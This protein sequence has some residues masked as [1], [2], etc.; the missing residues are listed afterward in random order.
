[1]KIAFDFDLLFS[2]F[3]PLYINFN[4]YT[5]PLF[6]RNNITMAIEIK[7]IS[8]YSST[9][10]STM[11]AVSLFPC[12]GWKR[13]KRKGRRNYIVEQTYEK[14]VEMGRTSRRRDSRRKHGVSMA[15]GRAKEAFPLLVTPTFTTGIWVKDSKTAWLRLGND[16]TI[17]KTMRRESCAKSFCAA[18]LR[19]R[20]PFPLQVYLV[21]ERETRSGWISKE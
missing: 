17:I 20:F 3:N 8:T 7:K 21:S 5:F 19:L 14:C 18:V 10:I 2:S 9:S 11:L 13:K 6:Q 15:R 1:M 12:R 16:V 4:L